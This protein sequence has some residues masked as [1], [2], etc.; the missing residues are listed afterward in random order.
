MTSWHRAPTA[1]TW[2]DVWSQR[3]LEPERGSILAQLLAADGFDTGF[4]DVG[5]VEWRRF[6]AR[7]ANRL[8]LRAG[9]SVFEV[10]C[11]A[12]AFLYPLAALGCGV[13]GVNQS[14]ALIRA[15]RAALPGCSFAIADAAEFPVE[16]QVDAVVSMGVFV[17]FPSLDYAAR[18]L[19]RMAAKA[20]GSVLLLDLPDV[21]HRDEALAYRKAS[22]GG[23]EEYEARYA[24]LHHLYYSRDWVESELRRAG[25]ERVQTADQDLGGYANARF[26]FNAWGRLPDRSEPHG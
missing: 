17:Y 19:G 8:G 2:K 25:V 4:G 24:G 13:G 3:R 26:R 21:A 22:V 7:W 11:G 12:G 14:P 16:P 20:R 9:S 10:G 5:E 15:A 1:R 18:V 6:V 23:A